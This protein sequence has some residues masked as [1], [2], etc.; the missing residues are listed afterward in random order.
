MN[1]DDYWPRVRSRLRMTPTILS[2][3]LGLR[4]FQVVT[5]RHIFK[6]HYRRRR[7]FCVKV[8]MEVLSME[9]FLSFAGLCNTRGGGHW[10][11]VSRLLHR[12]STFSGRR[13]VDLY[14][15]VR[16]GGFQKKRMVT[17]L[18]KVKLTSSRQC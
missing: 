16:F 4:P 6:R 1:T 15:K 9:T 11:A 10:Q 18:G 7:G 12:H 17:V 8:I 3:H 13:C 5:G 14:N 2:L